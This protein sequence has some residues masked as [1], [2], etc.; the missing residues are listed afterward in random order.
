MKTETLTFTETIEKISIWLINIED[1][2]VSDWIEEDEKQLMIQQHQQLLIAKANL[3]SIMR[4]G[5]QIF[6]SSISK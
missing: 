2:L 1:D 6:N 4:T 5:G 3:D